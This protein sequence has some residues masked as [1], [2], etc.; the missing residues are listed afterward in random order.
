LTS[1]TIPVTDK[2]IK[3]KN[4]ILMLIMEK[5]LFFVLH[6]S[7]INTEVDKFYILSKSLSVIARVMARPIHQSPK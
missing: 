6:L 1:K 3:K 4:L 7:N 2:K 5:K